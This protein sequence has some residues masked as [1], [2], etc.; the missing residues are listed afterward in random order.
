MFIG[1][2]P[3]FDNRNDEVE[4][5][6]SAE[7]VVLVTPLGNLIRTGWHFVRDRRFPGETYNEDVNFFAFTSEHY[8]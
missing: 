6:V 1:N 4:Y 8:V 3:Y 5:G 7:F 2:I